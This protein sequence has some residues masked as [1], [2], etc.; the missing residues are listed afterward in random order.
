MAMPW[1]VTSTIR[2]C[3]KTL[4]FSAPR[5]WVAKN[6]AKSETWAYLSVG[7][8]GN[9]WAVTRRSGRSD[10]LSLRDWRLKLGLERIV[11]G[12]GGWFVELGYAFKRRLEYENTDTEISLS[13]GILLRAGWNY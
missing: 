4:S 12:G 3:R 10:E 11:D 7:L 2:P 5:N 8:G 6:G 1:Y 13:D 9:T